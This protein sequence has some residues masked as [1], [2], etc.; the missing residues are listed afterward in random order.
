[1]GKDAVRQGLLDRLLVGCRIRAAGKPDAS[2]PAA[3]FRNDRSSVR[4]EVC[5]VPNLYPIGEQVEDCLLIDRG[6][7]DYAGPGRMTG[8]L[9]DR[10]P[11]A[12]SEQRFAVEAKSSAA[13]GAPVF[14]ERVAAT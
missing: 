8:D 9:A 13:D 4:V 11:F 6:G 14:A 2:E 5:L 12:P 3:A 1:M 10:E 7:R